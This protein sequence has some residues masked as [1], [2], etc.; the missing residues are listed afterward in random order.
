MS[1]EFE[2]GRN[3]ERIT[4]ALR[5]QNKFNAETKDVVNYNARFLGELAKK[6]NG[7]CKNMFWFS[8]LFLGLDLLIAWNAYDIL[9]LQQRVDELEKQDFDEKQDEKQD[10]KNA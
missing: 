7:L 6:H 3:V 9:K 4:E 8:V 10:G 5:K 2:F 1:N